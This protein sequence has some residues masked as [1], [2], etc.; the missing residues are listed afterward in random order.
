MDCSNARLGTITRQN[1]ETHCT[2][3][4]FG[5]ESTLLGGST[6]KEHQ[7]LDKRREELMRKREGR[8]NEERSWKKIRAEANG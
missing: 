7:L 1:A 6:E 3:Q 8:V 4:Y 5:I 2:K